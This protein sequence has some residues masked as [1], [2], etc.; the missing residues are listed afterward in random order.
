M[1]Q[2]KT[3]FTFDT[4]ILCTGFYTL[5]LSTVFTHHFRVSSIHLVV[6]HIIAPLWVLITQQ[7]VWSQLFPLILNSVAPLPMVDCPDEM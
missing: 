2:M 4:V 5:L 1:T 3:H 7:P 6:D